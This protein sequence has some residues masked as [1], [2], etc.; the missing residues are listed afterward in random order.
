MAYEIST[1]FDACERPVV[2]ALYWQAFG[3]KLGRVLGPDAR[4]QQFLRAVI[5]PAFA[6][7]ARGS[8]G[9][10]L[11]VAGFKTAEGALVGGDFKD[12]QAVYGSWGAVWRGLTLS[13]VERDVAP[14][15]LLMDGIC[16]HESARGLGVGTAL[17]EAV[18]SQARA[19]GKP[20]VRLD[21]IDRNP[22]ARALYLREGFVPHG[23]EHTGPFRHVFRF[24]SATQML[25]QNPV[26]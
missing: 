26:K 8:D 24:K 15:V 4:A 9:R 12:L 19:M 18:K 21:V 10:I 14:D 6:L 2:A 5:D 1:G 17:L 22:R 20:T 11:G 23:I 16:V 13:V 25:W 7:V 3:F